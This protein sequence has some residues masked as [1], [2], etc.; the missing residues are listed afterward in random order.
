MNNCAVFFGSKTAGYEQNAKIQNEITKETVKFC[1]EKVPEFKNGLWL[2]LG[3]G[4]GF[5]RKKL[6]GIF[7][8]INII[9]FDI[10][11]IPLLQNENSVCGDFDF[12]PFS[13][14]S[15]DKIISCSA[16]QWSKNIK[17]V[18]QNLFNAIKIDGKLIIAIFGYGTLEK[19]QFLQKKF[20][21]KPLVSFYKQEFLE[22]IFQE[23]GFGVT[24]K[25]ENIFLQKFNFAY[26]ALKSISKIG[27]ASHDGNILS[28]KSLKEFV[29]QYEKMFE[30]NEIIHEYKTFFYI[31]EKR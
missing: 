14:N 13:D 5:A 6:V 26:D 9:S 30:D 29:L 23:V 12:F 2:D 4:T 18:L 31:L 27:A 1:I 20:G 24:A 16:L 28:S 22:E 11:L 10:S 17:K 7:R 25:N 19:L 21:I 15:F 8:E 3:S